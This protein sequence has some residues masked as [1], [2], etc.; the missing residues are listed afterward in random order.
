MDLPL[1]E[2]R[3]RSASNGSIAPARIVANQAIPRPKRFTAKSNGGAGGIGLAN[4]RDE[5]E[6]LPFVAALRRA[7]E[8]VTVNRLRESRLR[9]EFAAIVRKA[10]FAHFEVTSATDA[11][12]NEL[13]DAAI[14]PFR[15]LLLSLQPEEATLRAVAALQPI[16]P[17]SVPRWRGP[18]SPGRYG[19]PQGPDF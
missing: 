5:A 11:M 13:S 10:E 18:A 4:C 8:T 7:E 19:C 9:D 14:Q 1:T 15:D 17:R 12:L 3:L 16:S 6:S 2:R